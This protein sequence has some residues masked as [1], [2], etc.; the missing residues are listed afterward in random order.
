MAQAVLVVC[1]VCGAP[2]VET[3]AIK[4]AARGYQEDLCRKHLEEMLAGARA[5]RRGRPRTKAPAPSSSNGVKRTVKARASAKGRA[6]KPVR[7][8]R[9]R[10]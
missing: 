8:I 3:A 9:K 10:A 1:D 5:P 7:A 2:A 4:V 6:R